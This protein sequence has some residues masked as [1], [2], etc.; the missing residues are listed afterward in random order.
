MPAVLSARVL[1]PRHE[2]QLK[3]RK[4]GTALPRPPLHRLK[5]WSHRLTKTTIKTS[6]KTTQASKYFETT[7]CHP[8]Q[9]TCHPS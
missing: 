8:P 2:N 7:A 9:L 4:T 3:Y 1:T 5:Y 6:A